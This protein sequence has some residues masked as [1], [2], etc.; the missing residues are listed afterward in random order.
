MPLRES[1]P[2]LGL[3]G[4]ELQDRIVEDA[5]G[6][7]GM[8]HLRRIRQV[9]EDRRIGRREEALAVEERHEQGERRAEADGLD[10]PRQ[11]ERQAA[12]QAPGERLG[13]EQRG[14][15]TAGQMQDVHAKDMIR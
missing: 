2:H 8:R 9:G 3:P 1:P 7:V 11:P 13:E 4:E 14:G 12:R 6:H 15:K 5:V 10:R